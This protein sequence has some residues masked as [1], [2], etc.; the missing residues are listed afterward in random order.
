MVDN[1]MAGRKSKWGYVATIA[2]GNLSRL[3]LLVGSLLFASAL[4]PTLVPRDPLPQGALAGLCFFIGYAIGAFVTWLWVYLGLPRID[5]WQI[6]T[7]YAAAVISLACVVAA[8]WRSADWQNSVRHAVG[9]PPVDSFNPFIVC[10]IAAV[11]FAVLLVLARLAK[12]LA[13]V[14]DRP[15]RRYIPPRVAI[16]LAVTLTTV[17]LWSLASD[18]LARAVFRL[19][20]ASYRQYDA[21]LEPERPQPEEAQRT[22]SSASLISWNEL[23]RAGREFVAS[24]PRASDIGAITERP[25][26]EPIRVYV[27]LQSEQTA[28][29]RARLALEELKR[30][31]GFSRSVL[32]VIIPT[33]TGW[34]DPAAIDTV[35]YLHDGDIA[36]V[37]V[38]YSYL[39]SPLSLL[40]HPEYGADTARA[41]FSQIYSYWT[42]L[43]KETRPKLYLY[44]L[45]LGAMNSQQST[46]LF[47]MIDDPVQ[48]AL[49]SG[50]PFTSALWKSITEERNAGSLAR[51]PQFRDGRL[52]RFMNQDGFPGQEIPQTWGPLRIV[53][54]QY[55]SD[56]IVFFSFEDFYRSPD[57]MREPLA[58]DVSPQLRW[59]PIVTGFQLVLDMLVANKTPMGFGHVYAP[60]HYIDAWVAV[61]DVR[62]WS[63]SQLAVL[64]RHFAVLQETNAS[65]AKDDAGTGYEGR[66][67]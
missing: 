40:A 13:V 38:Q 5:R 65:S 7:R 23:G 29:S 30:Q 51:L 20:D 50:P 61:T 35:E 47:E 22:G 60:E 28:E 45:S 56:P 43:P 10:G 37:A 67:G 6:A 39:S 2:L 24:G 49:W 62:G 14:I 32:I 4:T 59:Y 53:Y 42:K 34:V 18:V 21:L 46:R 58:R 1:A 11:T 16:T 57:W 19:L 33:G 17:I 12:G 63:Q 27:G 66:G 15:M 44:G 55:A 26:L 8:L 48:G 36:S 41:L 25:A 9:M 64:K 52:I 3:G 54:L 31:G